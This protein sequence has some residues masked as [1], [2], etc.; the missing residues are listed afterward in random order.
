MSACVACLGRRETCLVGPGGDGASN[1]WRPS[2]VG[3][4]ADGARVCPKLAQPM[5]DE[6]SSWHQVTAIT[7]E[8]DTPDRMVVFEA[9]QN[10]SVRLE[11]FQQMYAQRSIR[12]AS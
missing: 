7:I 12:N 11:L 2:A 6:L 4:W 8:L 3:S 10:C 1:R 5:P 9:V